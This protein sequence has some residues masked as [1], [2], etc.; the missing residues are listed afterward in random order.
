MDNA[1]L[2]PDKSIFVDTNNIKYVLK[3][4]IGRGGQG[5]VYATDEPDIALKFLV[6][7]N[8]ESQFAE[9]NLE[10][11]A[12]ERFKSKIFHLSHL[13]I[14]ESIKVSMPLSIL[15]EC[16]GYTLKLLGGKTNFDSF[17]PPNY[18]S[19]QTDEKKATE[20]IRFFIKTGGLKLRYKALGV[21]ATELSKLHSRGL[22]Y[23]DISSSNLFVI[24]EVLKAEEN[25]EER[26]SEQNNLN[27]D[28]SCTVWFIDADNI[29]Y[30][31][32]ISPY[33]VYTPGYGAP[34]IIQLMAVADKTNKA[35][36]SKM[37]SDCYS[38]SILSFKTIFLAQ[39][40]F[41]GNSPK[42]DNKDDIQ[43]FIGGHKQTVSCADFGS[44]PWINDSDD[45]SNALET[46]MPFNL[47]LNE[48]LQ[49]LYHLTF[50]S[51]KGRNYPY[52]RPS[53]FL[54]SYEFFRAYD[55]TITCPDCGFTYDYSLHSCP[56]C[57]KVKDKT[58]VFKTFI[59]TDNGRLKHS[60]WEFAKNII[61]SKDIKLPKRLFFPFNSKE[62]DE[63]I[64]S[65]DIDAEKKFIVFKKSIMADIKI[66]TA[67]R[68]SSKFDD[69]SPKMVIEIPDDYDEFF[70]MVIQHNNHYRCIACSLE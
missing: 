50:D 14:D 12:I 54:W 41:Y 38:F 8:S 48:N 51:N 57:D 62:Y 68:K 22:V 55:R 65:I 45:N 15:S 31:S 63:P 58:I 11:N 60:V 2:V 25:R 42:M 69:V 4:L 32:N 33:A 37:Y 9:L 53:I 24:S 44:L 67:M 19:L 66:S 59:L 39:H 43:F 36:T 13:Q 16:G 56:K 46:L 1:F 10:P 49:F 6:T 61:T 21:A 27:E 7:S 34:E 5:A 18:D 40:P 23:C 3:N 52:I 35:I 64:A 70:W 28:L 47:I 26:K 30:E 29:D 20:T 17:F